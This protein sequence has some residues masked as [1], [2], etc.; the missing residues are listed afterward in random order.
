MA[1]G[2][3]VVPPYFPARDRDFNLL[4]GALLYVYQNETTTKANIYTDEALTVL[5]SNP[6]VANSSGQ[7][8]AVYA[9]A[10]TEASPVLYSVSV[11]TSTGASPGNPFNF[12]NYRPSVDWE[13][14]AAALADAAALAAEAWADDAATSAA[15]AAADAALTAADLAAIEAIAAGSP[16]APSIV[17]KANLNGDNITGAN[18]AAFRTAIAAVGTTEL[19]AASGSALVGFLQSGAD[20]VARTV[21]SRLR[22]TV[23]VK[24]FGAVGDGV[25]NDAPAINDAL[26][27]AAT[28]NPVA[29]VF[30]P[31]GIYL[32]NTSILFS[33]DGQSLIGAGTSQTLIKPGMTD[34]SACISIPAGVDRWTL[35]DFYV[36]GTVNTATFATGATD[37]QNC[38][39]IEAWSTSSPFVTRFLFRDV[40]VRGCA[41]GIRIGGFS[42]DIER[43]RVD[44][45]EL[46]FEAT[47]LN[48]TLLNLRTE[49][50]RQDLVIGNSDGLHITRLSCQGGV[51]NEI[52]STIDDCRGLVLSAPYWETAVAYPRAEPFVIFG[53][54]TVCSSISVTGGIIGGSTGM[55]AGVYP[56]KLDRVNGRR[57]E[58]T[59]AD[60]SQGCSVLTTSNTENI[61]VIVV[62]ENGFNRDESMVMD[63]AIN[64]F[65]N[66]QF[67]AGLKGW[68]ALTP[69]RATISLETTGVRRGQY[70]LKVLATAG[71]SQNYVQFSL[72]SNVVTALRGKTMRL[73]V[74]LSTLVDGVPSIYL[75][76]D[77]GVTTTSSTDVSARIIDNAT[78]FAWADLTI[79]SDA[80]SVFVSVYANN[81][82]TNAAGTEYVLAQSI[83]LLD[84][85]VNIERQILGDYRDSD[86]L[87]KFIDSRVLY[88]DTAAPA[89]ADMS[90]ALGDVVY[91][92]SPSKGAASSRVCTTA[93]VGG[94]AVFTPVSV[95]PG[96]TDRVD[97]NIT[98]TAGSST[99]IQRYNA[100]SPFTA[101]RTVTLNT[102]GA[103]EGA[104]FRIVRPSAGAFVLNVGSGPLK[105]L[106]ANEWCEVAYTGSS[107]VLTGYGT[108]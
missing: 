75:Q 22:D 27:F 105:A 79:Q 74:T 96:L 38:I 19:A 49:G 25:T 37:A 95:L 91:T 5:S 35:A 88:Y 64:Y 51:A 60:G 63:A 73:M 76:S 42:G 54:T 2:R 52:A 34:G 9:E 67:E 14:A 71:Q 85:R 1:A 94:T 43:I 26:D 93:G 72:P 6:V 53:G 107:W 102:S 12:D 80:T 7:F 68:R 98:L 24:D 78:T 55:Q 61:D 56:I 40:R 65:P 48:D 16:D 83:S 57:F 47:L 11:T 8:P 10:G 82:D 97:Q 81:S 29:A 41:T 31:P 100:S 4:S 106:A 30:M 86:I 87:P 45:C 92:A 33:V 17:N 104:T 69:T 21:Q 23:S 3:F 18:I 101:D 70:A 44:Y 15:E 84:S 90:Y 66:S 89:D 32:C 20:A 58:A 103:W 13:T 28:Q 108:L 36:S 39:G 62:P 46:G 77:N 59:V 99:P 50:C